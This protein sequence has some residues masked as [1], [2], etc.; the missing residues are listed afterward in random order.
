MK[1]NEII[2]SYNEGNLTLI[3]AFTELR[4]VRDILNDQLASIKYFESEFINEIELEINEHQ[5]EYK[6]YVFEIRGGRKT[7]DFSKIEA[8]K[9]AKDN[10]KNLEAKYKMAF[11]ASQKGNT[12]IDED[13]GEVLEVPVMKQAKGSIIMKRKKC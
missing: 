7:Y 8:V 6:G 12:I 13:T 2:E 11:L 5:K 9:V 10:V 4:E 1:V 3:D